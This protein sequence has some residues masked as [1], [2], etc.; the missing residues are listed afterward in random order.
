L[1]SYFQN[2]MIHVENADS[3]VEMGG[4]RK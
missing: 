2:D 3:G 1:L 4:E